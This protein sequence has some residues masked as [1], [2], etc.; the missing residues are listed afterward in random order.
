MLSFPTETQ[1]EIL[2]HLP[3]YYLI[4]FSTVSKY[5]LALVRNHPWNLTIYVNNKMTEEVINHIITTYQFQGYSLGHRVNNRICN[6][7]H[8]SNLFELNLR[9]GHGSLDTGII[10]LC[11]IRKRPFRKINL[12][13]TDV[14]DVALEAIAQ[15]GCEEL[16]LTHNPMITDRGVQKIVASGKIHRLHL[17]YND[18]LTEAAFEGMTGVRR[19][20]LGTMFSKFCKLVFQFPNTQFECF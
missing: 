11:Q 20:H 5:F 10:Q 19:L 14:T 6:K 17:C 13:Y 4:K 1:I 18:Q 8:H 15:I 7:L 12:G 16:D 3:L 2:T 9:G